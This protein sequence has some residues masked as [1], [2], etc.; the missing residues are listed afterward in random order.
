[1]SKELIENLVW[2]GIFGALTLGGTVTHKL[3]YIDFDTVIRM[4]ISPIGLWMAWYGNRMPKT[5]VPAP[6]NARQA[7]R[8][9]SWS[10]VFSGL[11]YAGLW[12]FAPIPVAIWCGTGAVLGGLAMTLGYCFSL[13]RGPRGNA[14]ST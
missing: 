2:A 11:I 1:M 5:L 12:A 4:V 13:P 8:V 14:R 3:G 9:A 6:A 7:R 10:L